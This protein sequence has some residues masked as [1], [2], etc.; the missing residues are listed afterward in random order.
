[1]QA[2]F[3]KRKRDFQKL[4]GK[5]LPYVFN[6]HFVL[7]LVFF[8]GY[9]LY[10]YSQLLHHFPKNHFPVAII[11]IF[12]LL[13]LLRV[14]SPASYL[15]EADSHF[16]LCKE[17]EV[18]AYL[19]KASLASFIRWSSLQTVFLLLLYPVFIKLGVT[20]SL[21]ICLTLV[22]IVIKWFLQ[23]KKV[24]ALLEDGHLNWAKAIS[25]EQERKQR[26]LKFY[27]LFTNVKGISTRFKKRTY[28]NSILKLVPKKSTQLWSNLYLR[29]FLRS[30]DYLGLSLRLFLLSLLSLFF[31]SNTYL[32][33]ILT[34]VFT[35]LL[36]F[37]LLS[38][39]KHYDYHYLSLLYPTSGD[40]KKKNLL[41]F[42]RGLSAL[43]LLVELVISQSFFKAL[44][45][46]GIT[47]LLNFIY[48]PYKLKNIID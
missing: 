26:I 31:I 21:F 45:L 5:Y 10:Q 1:M 33:L 13:I 27:S 14:G 40:L 6:D 15:E 22:L 17:K 25:A 2:L 29:A 30:S 42:L 38:L 23:K 4:H 37:Q 3:Q 16:L 12:L 44:V 32:S 11:L 35:Y 20:L 9:I 34:G 24:M 36:L 41:G 7:V 19:K 43:I 18:I 39:Y 48:I 47:L 8:L 46:I 28:L